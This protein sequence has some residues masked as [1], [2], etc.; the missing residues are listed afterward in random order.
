MGMGEPLLNF[1]ETIKSL[2]IFA[3]DLTTG[4]NPR[5]ITVSTA[6]IAPKIK[7][8]EET[9]LKVKLAFSLHS[10]FEEIR[11]NIM[12]INKKYSLKENIEALKSYAVKTNTRITFEY[13]MLE[14]INDR[15]EDIKALA[16]LM[17]TIPSKLN[18]IPFNSL[19][20][21]DPS[22]FSGK[23]RS[24]PMERIHQFADK[25]REKNITVM[26]RNTQGDDIAAACGQLAIKVQN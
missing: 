5:K 11:S 12:P 22:G 16:R 1:N 9:K 25:L 19:E 24:T 4:I 2:G 21:M 3:E 7:E 14:G 15:N 13:V 8:L 20:H 6:G 23:L 10:C 17:S 26:L 18:I